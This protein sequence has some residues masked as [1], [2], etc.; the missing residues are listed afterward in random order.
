MNSLRYLPLKEL[1]S[2]LITG[3]DIHDTGK[4]CRP[5]PQPMGEACG[6]RGFAAI[7]L[8]VVIAVLAMLTAMLVPALSRGRDR[9]L[10]AQCLSNKRQLAMACQMYSAENNNYLVPTAP[11]AA[12]SPDLSRNYGWC[13]GQ[14]SWAASRW[15]IDADAYRVTVLGPYVQN[16]MVYKCPGDTIPS[17]NGDRIRSIS[18]NPALVGDLEAAI[19]PTQFAQLQNMLSGYQL[20]KKMSDLGVIGVANIWVFCDESMYTLNDGYLQCNLRPVGSPGYPDVPAAYH[21]GGN[22]FSFAD[23]H[24][25]F[26]KWQCVY[27]V[28]QFGL[29]NVP[30]AKDV[31][32]PGSGNSQDASALDV[33]W[34]WLRAHTSCPQ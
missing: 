17:D 3:V 6:G 5:R 28:A 29:L 27:T 24:G 16:V 21:G 4:R 30:Y 19:G 25:E 12:Q 1:L 26:K 34:R 2:G 11:V 9:A 15:N 7:E 13:P 33:D 23:G 10:T 31:K 32:E 18:M 8:L 14:V 20:F 22:C